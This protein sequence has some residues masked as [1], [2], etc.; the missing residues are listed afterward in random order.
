MI[1]PN[2]E[3]GH[4][5]LSGWQNKDPQVD[6]RGGGSCQAEEEDW[7]VLLGQ[8]DCSWAIMEAK[9]WVWEEFDEDMEKD[10]RLATEKFWQ[11]KGPG[12][13]SRAQPSL[14]CARKAKCSS[15]LEM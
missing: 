6:T 2:T 12:R 3:E 15:R 14:C 11:I 10:F 7:L 4:R 8:E 5:C 9:T 13:G 1:L